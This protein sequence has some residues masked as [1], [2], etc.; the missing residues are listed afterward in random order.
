MRLFVI[1]V[2]IITML[3]LYMLALATGHASIFSDYFWW[4][5]GFNALA[6]GM[7]LFSVGRQVWQL[8]RD[9][10]KRVFGARIAKRLTMMFAIVAI[11]PGLF[12]FGVSAQFIRH[13]IDSWF[14]NETEVALERSLNLSKVALNGSVEDA[15]RDAVPLQIEMARAL[16]FH[17]DVALALSGRLQ[18]GGYR[19]LALWDQENKKFVEKVGGGGQFDWPELTQQ[20]WQRL[21]KD[22]SIGNLESV[23]NTLYINGWLMIPQVDESNVILF[24]RK[25]VPESIAQDAVLIEAAR[26]KYAELSYAKQGLQAFFVMTL[27]MATVLAISLALLLAVYFSRRF[28]APLS[29]LADGTRAVAQGDFSQKSPVLRTD[30]MGILSSLFNRMTEQLDVA[31]QQ[32]EKNRHQQEVARAYLEQ[33]LASLSTG[34]ISLNANGYLRTYNDSAEQILGMDLM[35]AETLPV[36]QWGQLGTQWGVLAKIIEE[37]CL[38]MGD[39]APLQMD[40]IGVD[41][42]QI[43]LVKAA[44]IIYEDMSHTVIIFDDVTD[45]VSAQKEAAWGEVAK[46]LAHEI[47]NPLTPIQLSAERLAWKLQDKLSEDDARILVRSTDTIVKQVAALKEMVEA[48][49]NYARSPSL[50]PVKQDLRQVVNEVLVLYEGSICNFQADLGNIP[51]MV[52]IDTALMR[53]VLH[54][55]FKNAAEAAELAERPQVDIIAWSNEQ[56]VTLTVANNGQSFQPAILAKAFEPYITDKK[57]G[58]GLGLAVVKKIIDDHQGKITLANQESGGAIIRIILPKMEE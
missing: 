54:N 47:R 22:G 37:T 9:G 50:R 35:A 15:L 56:T 42:A 32:A 45:L 17:D 11:L 25:P 28:V 26:A 4:I 41:Q 31:K 40:Y 49:R 18:R 53:Q 13:S 24:F 51:L 14:G 44:P 57:N 46:R 20:D 19:Q 52:R 6:L 23:Q 29:A 43:L 12:L 16:V 8:W 10:R 3:L 34:V 21:H 58:T 30:E 5:F 33:V 2:A 39:T 1:A 48:F 27:L 7:L 38:K 55:I 36:E